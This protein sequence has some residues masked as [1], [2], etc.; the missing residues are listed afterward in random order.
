MSS[1]SADTSDAEKQRTWTTNMKKYIETLSYQCKYLPFNLTTCFSPKCLCYKK[2]R[3]N[4]LALPYWQHRL[5]YLGTKV[6][7]LMHQEMKLMPVECINILPKVISKMAVMIQSE[8]VR[9][10]STKVEIIRTLARQLL[11][12]VIMAMTIE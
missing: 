5:Q 4:N 1:F 10:D 8:C 12:L 7:R 9:V 3:N 2:V 11:D 6:N